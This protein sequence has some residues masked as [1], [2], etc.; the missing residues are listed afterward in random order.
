[1]LPVSL[2]SESI[3]PKDSTLLPGSRATQVDATVD[4]RWI[5][6]NVLWTPF[7]LTDPRSRVL[8]HA[9]HNILEVAPY[10]V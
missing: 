8:D 3:T 10:A 4:N 5:R 9:H 1:M 7:F 2:T 6:G